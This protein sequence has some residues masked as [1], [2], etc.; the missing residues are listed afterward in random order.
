MPDYSYV[1]KGLG[2][3]KGPFQMQ[4]EKDRMLEDRYV[5][6]QG[7]RAEAYYKTQ[8]GL[9]EAAGRKADASTSA[10]AAEADRL[11]PKRKDFEGEGKSHSQALQDWQKEYLAFMWDQYP[12]VASARKLRQ[13]DMVSAINKEGIDIREQSTEAETR[14]RTSEAMVN[15][16][17]LESKGTEPTDSAL[18][19]AEEVIKRREGD[20][21]FSTGPSAGDI[22]R[23]AARMQELQKAGAAAGGSSNLED[24]SE[25]A[26]DEVLGRQQAPA[27]QGPSMLDRAMEAI[28]GSGTNIT[29]PTPMPNQANNPNLPPAMGG[30]QLAPAQAPGNVGGKRSIDLSNIR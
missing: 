8:L 29:A 13:S 28:T 12:D 17:G 14:R 23:V 22:Q 9:T 27:Q 26:Y 30:G 2:D 1:S 15:E 20:G 5:Q 24:Y 6:N 3:I 10:R 4:E 7:K 25:Q 11:A 21:M 18:F 19:S 16:Q